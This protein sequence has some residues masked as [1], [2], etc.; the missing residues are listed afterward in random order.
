MAY[1][2]IVEDNNS[3]YGSHKEKIM[4]KEKLFNKLWFLVPPHYNGYDMSQCTLTLRYLLPISKEF[5]TETLILSEDKYEEYLKYVLPIDTDLSKEWGDIELNLTFTLL[6]VDENGNPVQRVRKTDNHI[7]RITQLPNWDAFVP[8]SALS[9]LDQRILKQ[10]AQIRALADLA[11]ILDNNQVDNLVYNDKEDTLQLSAN[12]VGIGNKVFVKDML[13]DGVPIVDLDS[14]SGSSSDENQ[15][16]NHGNG[17]NCGCDCDDNVV[18]FG[19]SSD[20]T[21]EQEDDY[22]VVEF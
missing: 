19:H 13:D 1:T 18:E 10:D 22:N 16:N 15:D 3:L 2:I 5:K 20:Y 21:E 6:D 11:N 17:C 7:L 9:A 14:S 12:G 8:D 4:Q